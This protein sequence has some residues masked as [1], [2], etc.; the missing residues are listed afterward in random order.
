MSKGIFVSRG[1]RITIKREM[2]AKTNGGNKMETRHRRREEMK[3][4]A[5]AAY[6]AAAWLAVNY[7]WR[8][9]SRKAIS[10]GVKRVSIAWRQN[11]NSIAH[12]VAHGGNQTYQA[13]VAGG[14]GV[15]A[16]LS[17]AWWRSA[18]TREAWRR[19]RRKKM[20][21]EAV[22][23]GVAWRLNSQAKS[24][25]AIDDIGWLIMTAK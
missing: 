21:V 6:H 1:G 25:G 23:G 24:E 14:G 4:E 12:G 3:N 17:A 16:T 11:N 19:H 10:Y 2:M 5:A 8:M 13:L 9:A 15:K 22:C 7:S 20:E 18:K